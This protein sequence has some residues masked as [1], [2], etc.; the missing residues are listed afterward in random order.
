[1]D[2]S[3]QGPQKLMKKILESNCIEETICAGVRETHGLE[4]LY[5]S[6][7]VGVFFLSQFYKP[8]ARTSF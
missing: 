5:K 7:C 1:M 3:D 6:S 4:S 8:L 2:L